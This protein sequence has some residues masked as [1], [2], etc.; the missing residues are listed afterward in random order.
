MA[1]VLIVED[2]FILR[3]TMRDVLHSADHEVAVAADGIRGLEILR[4]IPRRVVVLLDLMMPRKT[5]FDP[6]SDVVDNQELARRHAFVLMTANAG[7]LPPLRVAERM[8][9]LRL[10]VPVLAKPF[11]RDALLQVIAWAER[12]LV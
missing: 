3:E 4:T 11:R 7:L 5:G 1:T 10:A 2:D 6:L 8:A 12:H 9:A